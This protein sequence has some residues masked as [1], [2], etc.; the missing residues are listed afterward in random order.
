MPHACLP[1][2]PPGPAV[3][4]VEKSATGRAWRWRATPPDGDRRAAA[5]SQAAGL[6]GLV[7]ELLAGRGVGVEEAAD[8]LGPTLRRLLP[9]PA[10]LA[11]MDRA[12]SRLA[13]AV[14]ARETV[15]V[16]GDYDVDGACAA[17][18]AAETLRA[19]GCRVLVHIPDRV[20]E[21]YGPNRAAI[22][23][24]AA[25]GATLV[26]CVDCGTAA[27]DVLDP[28]ATD[29]LDLLV[30]DHHR[31]TGRPR[32]VAT[33]N[34]NRPDD[35]SGLGHLCAAGVVFLALVATLRALRRR[36]R[37]EAADGVDLRD[38]LDLVALATVC[39]VVPLRG[40][41]RAFVASGLRV[42]ARRARPGLAALLARAGGARAPDSFTCGYAIGPRI[43]AGG[44][45]GDASL[46]VRLLLTRDADEAEAIA[47]RLDAVNRDRQ[48][49]EAAILAGAIG[50]AGEQLGR[51]RAT[52]VLE[53][54]DWH[55]GVVGIVA[56]RL[57]ERFNRPACVGARTGDATKGSG[58]SVPG[59][60]LGGAIVDARAHGLLETG[61]GHAMAAGYGH[62]AGA[63]TAFHDFLDERLASASARLARED[64]ACEGAIA[65]RGATADL[66][67]A[68]G[69]LA[70]FGQGNEEPVL[71]LARA[72]VVRADRLGEEGRVVRAIVEGEGGEGRVKAMLFRAGAENPLA[73]LLLGPGAPPLHLAGHLRLDHWNGQ[74]TACFAVEDAALA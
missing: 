70:P 21:G 2:H 32:I 62:R 72:R 43:N 9:D 56:S 58:R 53:G 13:D 34:P 66:A 57:R 31:A 45:L 46:G 44:R 47:A 60:D 36:G 61:G 17:A 1:D 54:A 7:G 26:L 4:G 20:A 71:V 18:L 15:G 10:V 59:L 49:V 6:P 16:F 23:G 33:V 68:L 67:R 11:D 52:I 48:T 29:G 64:L 5:L 69:R 42:M 51:G 30:L 28:L 8:F 40:V 19:L 37:A 35:V 73:A 41:N 22:A 39:D 25:G 74:E 3:L 55:P 63:A 24:L 14:L 12:A 50:Q 27:A 65:P 38:G